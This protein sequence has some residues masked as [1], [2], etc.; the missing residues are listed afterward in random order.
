M[1]AVFVNGVRLSYRQAGAGP[2]VVLVHGIGANM[3]FWRMEVVRRLARRFRV[4]VYDLRGHGYSDMAPSGY[5][6]AAMAD[7]LRALLDE[8]GIERAHLVGHSFGGAIALHAA[9]LCPDRALSL[10]LADTVLP[11]LQPAQRLRDWPQWER[12]AERVRGLGIDV[13]DE[14][15]IDQTLLEILAQPEWRPARQGFDVREPLFLPFAG[16]N[17]GKRAAQRWLRLLDTTTA[18]EE[19]NA[20]GGLTGDRIR[21]VRHPTLAIYGEYSHGLPTLDWLGA[22]LASCRAVVVPGVGHYH[23]AVKPDFFG[24]QVEQFLSGLPG[25]RAPH[26]EAFAADSAAEGADPGSDAGAVPS[27][28]VVSEIEGGNP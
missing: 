24:T 19:I 2:D 4:T 18:R 15:P 5:G 11:A 6:T 7:D 23:P 17:G 9:M 10:V 16:W 12:W 25:K 13:T 8:I 27:A 21:A 3:A 22:N 1:A 28:A 26:A 14:Q 20:P